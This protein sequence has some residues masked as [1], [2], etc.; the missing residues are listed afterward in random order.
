MLDAEQQL[1]LIRY[2]AHLPSR[3]YHEFMTA[4]NTVWARAHPDEAVEGAVMPI[5]QALS[6]IKQHSERMNNGQQSI[7]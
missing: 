7:S 5:N 3:E 6:I 1:E 2:A 4:L